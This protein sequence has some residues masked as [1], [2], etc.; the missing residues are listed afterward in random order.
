MDYKRNPRWA[1]LGLALCLG[2]GVVLSADALRLTN[3]VYQEIEVARP[4]GTVERKV[5]PAAKV[6]PGDEVLYVIAYR[7]EGQE[8]AEAV[9]ITNPLVHELAYKQDSAYAPAAATF[10][11]SV[12][13]GNLFG[14][15]AALE[16]VGSAGERRAAG[17]QD[18]THL[19]WK[20]HGAVPPGAEGQVGFRAILR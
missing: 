20:L 19:R 13:G 1:A 11:V 9:V 7:N 15:L 3:Q 8:P 5:V 10:E 16:I 17:A 14:N 18:V 6:T 4:D 12:D 2:P